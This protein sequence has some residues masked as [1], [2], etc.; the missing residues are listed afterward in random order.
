MSE[1]SRLKFI[2]INTYEFGQPAIL[3]SKH[4]V[5]SVK[6]GRLQE[7]HRSLWVIHQPVLDESGKSYMIVFFTP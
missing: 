6:K 3:A 5:N 2:N 1:I 4:A 7:Q